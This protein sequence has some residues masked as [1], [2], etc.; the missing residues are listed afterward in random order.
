[1]R[2]YT[3]QQQQ[4]THH[5]YWVVMIRTSYYL[6]ARRVSR[7]HHHPDHQLLQQH[8]YILNTIIPD[9]DTT[10]TFGFDKKKVILACIY[11]FL[12]CGE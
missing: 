11:L 1:M 3:A 10:L 12:L 2:E 4:R 8:T 5:Y 7:T 9:T 6:L